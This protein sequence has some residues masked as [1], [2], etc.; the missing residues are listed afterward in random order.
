MQITEE[1]VADVKI[2]G[3][4]GRLDGTTSPGVEQ[5]L[6]Q[7]IA[8]GE[9]RIALDFT[10][11][12]YVSSNG[13]RVLMVVAKQIQKVGGRLALFALSENVSEILKIAGFTQLFSIYPT[14][15]EAVQHCAG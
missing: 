1:K 9:L 4:Q 3:L 7:C 8:Q 2:I 6:T 10:G 11:L 13:L 5:K 15:E 12:I 14:R